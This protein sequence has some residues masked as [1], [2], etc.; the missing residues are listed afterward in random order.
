MEAE[1]VRGL[2]PMHDLLPLD[3][4]TGWILGIASVRGIDFQ[5]IDLRGKLGIARGSRG[6]QPC[7]VAAQAASPHGP[8]IVG[9]IADR[10]SDVITLRSQEV[11]EGVVRTHGRRRRILNPDVLL[12]DNAPAFHPV[13]F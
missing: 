4:P 13:A 2:L 9:F 1:R 5:V 3:A 12:L 7:I 8:Q 6:R 10:V 11:L